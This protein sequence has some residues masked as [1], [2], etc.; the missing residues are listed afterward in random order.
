KDI[1]PE[2]LVVLEERRERTENNPAALLGEH[3]NAALYLNHPYQRPIIGWPDEIKA[4][5]RKDLLAFYRYWYAP[6]NAVLIV[7]GDITA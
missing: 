1:E 4:L 3:V 2:R 5:S 7:A 6:N